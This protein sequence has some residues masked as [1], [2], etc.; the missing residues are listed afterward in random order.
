MFSTQLLNKF[1]ENSVSKVENFTFFDSK[2]GYKVEFYAV[3]DIL[4]RVFHICKK[5]PLQRIF[6]CK[7]FLFTFFQLFSSVLLLLFIFLSLDT[8][9]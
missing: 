5:K 9:E 1:V 7:G 6:C 3:A 4:D 2:K 8:A